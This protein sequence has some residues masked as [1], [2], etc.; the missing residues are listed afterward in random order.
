MKTSIAWVGLG[1][2]LTACGGGSGSSDGGTASLAGTWG[3]Q[4]V[5][6]SAPPIGNGSGARI[7]LTLDG[8]GN[9]TTVVVD[10]QTNGTGRVEAVPDAPGIYEYVFSL[11]GRGG[12]Y[13]DPT[14]RYA[15]A[16]DEDGS[17]AVLQRDG[18]A[19]PAYQGEDVFGSWGGES[20]FVERG[21][22]YDGRVASQVT[23][24]PD[25][26]FTGAE[27]AQPFSSLGRIDFYSNRTDPSL[28]YWWGRF[29]SV[30][31]PVGIGRL[32][33]SSDKGF[34]TGFAGANGGH[35][36]SDFSFPV[37]QKR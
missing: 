8:A 22:V 17:L 33:M 20:I 25:G 4:F 34:L 35:F 37:W 14:G 10:G 23:V 7:Q 3:G 36:P 28:A 27:D 32:L 18:A 31:T 13:V 16:V 9:I 26:N 11:G 15:A 24:T 30:E 1:L 19:L 2:V 12:F 29:S 21:L 6:L 5:K